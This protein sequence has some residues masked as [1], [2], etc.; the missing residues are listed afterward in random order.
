[1]VLPM[2]HRQ[3]TKPHTHTGHRHSIQRTIS[4]IGYTSCFCHVS[5]CGVL[6]AAMALAESNTHHDLPCVALQHCVFVV[7]QF[8]RLDWLSR[9]VVFVCHRAETEA[10]ANS[11][12]EQCNLG[13]YTAPPFFLVSHIPETRGCSPKKHQLALLCRKKT[14]FENLFVPR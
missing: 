13:L 5:R 11:R 8:M 4:R 14:Q 10:D 9:E 2:R 3:T 12:Q 1:M 6:S 7:I